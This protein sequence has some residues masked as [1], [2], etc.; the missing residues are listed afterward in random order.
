MVNEGTRSSVK[1][2]Q[3]QYE[4]E[5]VSRQ[6]WLTR[7]D[8]VVTMLSMITI[9]FGLPVL[10]AAPD[11]RVDQDTLTVCRGPIVYCLEDVDY[12]NLKPITPNFERL[13]IPVV[14]E[15][16]EHHTQIEGVPMVLLKT[17]D[18]YGLPLAERAALHRFVDK[19]TPARQW[20]KLDREVTF[21]PFFARANRG[22]KGHH[23][24]SLLRVP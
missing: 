12:S 11:P 1:A 16:T 14:A 13:G 17:R 21:V 6:R 24:T 22:G 4:Y 2:I 10:L 3:V 15:Y 8:R 5:R 7:T 23:R 9:S 18:I 19:D 20:C